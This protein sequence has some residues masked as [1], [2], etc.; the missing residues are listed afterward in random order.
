M[1]CSICADVGERMPFHAHTPHELIVCLSDGGE[2]YLEDKVYPFTVGRTFL[3]PAGVSH[4]VTGE[5]N[6]HAKIQFICFDTPL[7]ASLGVFP[8]V[9]YFLSDHKKLLVS[10]LNGKR[11]GDENLRLAKQLQLE[12]DGHSSYGEV[13]ARAILTQLLI[14]HMRQLQVAPVTKGN[15]KAFAIERC[16]SEILEDIAAP[17]CLTEMSKKAGM[18]RSAFVAQFKTYTGVGM[19]EFVN[20]HRVQRA[21]RQLQSSDASVTEIA[22]ALGFGNLG[23]F[24]TVFKKQVGMTPIEYREWAR[25]QYEISVPQRAVS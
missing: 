19:V 11:V 25:S 10:S 13:M 23:H 22:F 14:N 21:Q 7:L 12:L 9:H 16:C 17:R 3:L 2:L 4:S 8:L 5:K 6:T 20:S 18:S 15:S 1:L 24:Y